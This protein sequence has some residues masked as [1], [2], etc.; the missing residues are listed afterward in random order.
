MNYNPLPDLLIMGVL[1]IG[2]VVVIRVLEKKPSGA[3]H[4]SDK[5]ILRHQAGR[6]VLMGDME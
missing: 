6:R 3:T 4:A 2:L 1:L 5:E